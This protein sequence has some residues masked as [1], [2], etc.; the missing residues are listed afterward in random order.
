MSKSKTATDLLIGVEY[1]PRTVEE[2]VAEVLAPHGLAERPAR[3]TR[4]DDID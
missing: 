4:R 2:V 1:S 3:A